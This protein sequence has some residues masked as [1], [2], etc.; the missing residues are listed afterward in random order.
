[1]LLHSWAFLVIGLNDNVHS[2]LQVIF[3]LNEYAVQ[4]LLVRRKPV[5]YS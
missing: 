4:L 5:Y 1:M 2:S 3:L